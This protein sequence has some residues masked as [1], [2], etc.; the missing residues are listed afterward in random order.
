VTAAPRRRAALADGDS[1]P[2]LALAL[3]VRDAAARLPDALL[4]IA[5]WCARARTPLEVLVVDDGSVD[6]TA[7]V[8]EA[9]RR[10]LPWLRV[11]RHAEPRG[12]GAALRTAFQATRAT[13]VVFGDADLD[14]PVEQ[15]PR[16]LAAVV[17]GADV[18]VATPGD[19]AAPPAAGL[20]RA[21]RALSAGVRRLVP[22]GLRAV[23]R[24]WKALRLRTAKRLCAA[25]ESDGYD[26]DADWRFLAK[27]L[28]ARVVETPV[29]R[30]TAPA[31]GA[32]RAPAP[33]DVD[34]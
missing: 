14:A 2:R 9:F 29:P 31:R 12:P 15:L 7:T 22:A 25:A 11:L 6:G 17:E 26:V 32:R 28:G 19:V 10:R 8:A 24:G 4:A 16:L 33:V 3:P 34:D 20:A 13:V 18:A 27:R 21:A 5:A 1:P 23:P 30:R